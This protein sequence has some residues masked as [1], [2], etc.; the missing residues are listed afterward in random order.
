M[1]KSKSSSR[2]KSSSPKLNYAAQRDGV[3]LEWD[4]IQVP[5]PAPQRGSSG[6]YRPGGALSSEP[7]RAT[8]QIFLLILLLKSTAGQLP[9]FIPRYS[10]QTLRARPHYGI[11]YS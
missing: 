1:V 4:G 6:G 3:H 10:R 8:I 9:G 11:Y 2:R 7:Y 5:Y